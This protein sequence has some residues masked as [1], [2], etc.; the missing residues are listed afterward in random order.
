LN[1]V[2]R[3]CHERA[4]TLLAKITSIEGVRCRFPGPF[5]H[6]IVI[7]VPKPAS[8]VLDS[9]ARDGILAGYDLGRS[10][11]GLEHCILTNVTETKSDRDLDDFRDCLLNA[12][13]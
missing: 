4:A 9:M 2:A 13:I 6:E 1:A 3:T 11:T 8:Q 7:E 10:F 5:F 12:T